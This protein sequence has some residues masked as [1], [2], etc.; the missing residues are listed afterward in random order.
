M[1]EIHLD[2]DGLSRFTTFSVKQFTESG[3]LMMDF[4]LR[5]QKAFLD[6]MAKATEEAFQRI[7]AEV[8]L[9][10]EFV[11]RLAS[12]HSVNEITTACADIG[13]HQADA[14]RQDS[15]SLLQHSQQLCDET[16]R[17]LSSQS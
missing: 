7:S 16:S 15:Q 10:S 5:M 6:E 8:D 12:A 9:A 11:A 14:F 2:T 1:T 4:S 3:R 17:I 13:E